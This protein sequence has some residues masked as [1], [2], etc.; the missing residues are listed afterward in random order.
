MGA[1]ERGRTGAQKRRARKRACDLTSELGDGRE[2]LADDLLV[3]GV[4]LHLTTR[5]DGVRRVRE[6]V[7]VTEAHHTDRP[8]GDG[9]EKGRAS[10]RAPAERTD[11]GG[12]PAALLGLRHSV[13]HDGDGSP[14]PS[15]PTSAA[16]RRSSSFSAAP[17]SPS[18]SAGPQMDPERAAAALDAAETPES[19]RCFATCF[20]A[21]NSDV[22]PRVLLGG[23]VRERS[24]GWWMEGGFL[25]Q[26]PL[27]SV[28][29]TERMQK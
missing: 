17:P 16:K 8:R 21:R 26:F 29:D 4:A 20:A 18:P 9:G 5:R 23:G 25:S 19:E 3:R 15:S 27:E 11:A 24:T 2:Q 1:I 28:T 10:E 6:R 13:A 7:C 14:A 12:K 22:I